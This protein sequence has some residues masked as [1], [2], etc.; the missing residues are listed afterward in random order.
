MK[1]ILWADEPN[2][3]LGLRDILRG[4]GHVPMI[5]DA[6]FFGG[7]ADAEKADAIAF[8]GA[9]AQDAILT[10]YRSP[11]YRERGGEVRLVDIETGRF[12]EVLAVPDLGA[13]EPPKEPSERDL[14][15]DRLDNLSDDDLRVFARGV[16]GRDIDAD[17]SREDIEAMLRQAEPGEGKP[18]PAGVAAVEAPSGDD[19]AAPPVETETPPAPAEP[20]LQA[21]K[22]GR[23]VRRQQPSES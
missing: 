22:A 11:A 10:A 9:S 5:R 6:R 3:A 20:A 7:I 18:S 12:G 2:N 13:A 4:Q 23:K 19:A 21:E 1:V 14:L 17:A 15:N 8:I 16:L